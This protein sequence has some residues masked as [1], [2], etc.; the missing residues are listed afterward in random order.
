M[1]TCAHVNIYV[2]L[3]AYAC[4]CFS[5]SVFVYGCARINVKKIFIW[6]SCDFVFYVFAYI[7]LHESALMLVK[8]E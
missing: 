7:C 6:V 4:E 5:I 3:L 8:N 2:R 1:H